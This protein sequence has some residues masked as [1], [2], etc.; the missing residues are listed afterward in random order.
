LDD[1]VEFYHK[2]HWVNPAYLRNYMRF[3]VLE[4]GFGGFTQQRSPKEVFFGYDDP[5]LRNLK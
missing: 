5:F 4:V 2:Y 3:I 1:D